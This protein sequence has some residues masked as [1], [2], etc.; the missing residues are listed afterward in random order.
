MATPNVIGLAGV[1]LMTGGIA[2]PN[3]LELCGL[4]LS[5][6][7]MLKVA[8]RKPVATG[9]K[10]TKIWQLAPMASVVLHVVAGIASE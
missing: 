1:G 8:V 4:L 5:E 2:V 6:S 7:E 3:R 9:V 10:L